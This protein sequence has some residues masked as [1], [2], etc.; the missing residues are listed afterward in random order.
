MTECDALVIGS[1]AGGSVAA[2]ELALAGRSVTVLEEGPRVTTRELVA[3]SPAASMRRLYR[4]GGATPILGAPPIAF[5]EGRCVGG[6][7]VINGGLLWEPSAALLDRWAAWTGY[8]GY[9]T[10]SLGG[11]FAEI[12]TRLGMIVQ[13]HGDGNAD[14]RLLAEAASSQGWRWQHPQRV[15]TGC[16]HRN[17]CATGCPSGAKQ[18]MAASY[19]PRAEA[20]GAV[21]SPHTRVDRLTHERGAVRTVEATGPDG[22]RLRYRPRTVFLAAGATGS[23]ALLRRSGIQ[24]RRAGRDMALHVNLRT[25]ARFPRPVDAQHGTI[26]T[27][28]VQEFSDLGI[29]IM[30]ANQTAGSLGAALAG[31]DPR[32]VDACLDARAHLATYTTQVR[33]HGTVAMTT[34]VGGTPFL[35]HRMTGADH[36]ALRLAFRRT[37]HLLLAAGATELIPPTSGVGALR[38]R[39]DVEAYAAHVRPAD[40]E[41]VSVHGMAGCRMAR[42]ERGGV[43]DDRG[44]PHGFTNLHVCDAGV[45]PGATGISPQGTIMAYAHEIVRRHLESA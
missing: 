33:L 44:R 29:L 11:H 43:C 39:D 36:H 25:I 13:E 6:T 21:I 14:S 31:R 9:R 12:S 18:S 40:W 20:L 27:A 23:P 34:G 10:P 16:L 26:F 2:L 42:P 8:D 24:R 4:N 19:L 38:T 32:L 17:Q 30:P 7:T 41:L 1:G 15:V 37:A 3:A 45:L 5:A 35:R 22:R 28:Q